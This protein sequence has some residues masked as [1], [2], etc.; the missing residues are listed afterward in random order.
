MELINKIVVNNND[1][2]DFAAITRQR[3][4]FVQVAGEWTSWPNPN[5]SLVEIPPSDPE[6]T[7]ITTT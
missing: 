6:M 7:D 1:P 4:G 2:E 3:P 5:W